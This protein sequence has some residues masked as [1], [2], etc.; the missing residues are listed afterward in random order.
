M[1]SRVTDRYSVP[2]DQLLECCQLNTALLHSLLCIT[3][4]LLCL[5]TAKPQELQREARGTSAS[6]RVTDSYL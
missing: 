6:K 5:G 1:A 3:A 4:I 2:K